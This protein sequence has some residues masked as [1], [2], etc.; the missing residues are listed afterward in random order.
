MRFSLFI[1]HPEEP[2]R[3]LVSSSRSPTHRS[4]SPL[5]RKFSQPTFLSLPSRYKYGSFHYDQQQCTSLPH[6]TFLPS[7][8]IHVTL[9]RGLAAP[10]TSLAQQIQSRPYRICASKNV[11]LAGTHSVRM[12]LHVLHDEIG[13]ATSPFG[14]VLGLIDAASCQS[15][16]TILTFQSQ[17]SRC[18]NADVEIP[19]THSGPA[20]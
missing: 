13:T 19:P 1:A 20:T 16:A 2:A 12:T 5:S 14:V 8:V 9:E 11:R 10:T 15:L 6:T 4:A 7:H 17:T 18:I 3:A